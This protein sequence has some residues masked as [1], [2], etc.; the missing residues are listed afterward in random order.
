M[1]DAAFSKYI[2]RIGKPPAPMIA[3]YDQI[4]QD[5][6]AFVLQDI[7]KKVVGAIVLLDSP[8]S[9]SIMIDNIVVDPTTQ[10]RGYGRVLLDFATDFARSQGRSAI[11]L[12]TNAKMYENLGLYVKLGFIETGRRTEDGFERVYF[13]KDILV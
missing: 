9:R 13:R 8:D 1:V 2:E 4:I 7:E 12:Y 6:D 11:T 3:N 10:G 5:G